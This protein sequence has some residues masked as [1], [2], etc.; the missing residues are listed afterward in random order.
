MLSTFARLQMAILKSLSFSMLQPMLLGRKA[1]PFDHPEFIFELKYDGFRALAIIL[2]GEC[3]LV[4]RNGNA[5]RSFE[6]LR[7]DFRQTSE[8]APPS[9]IAKSPVSIPH[10]GRC[11]MT[12][13]F[14]RRLG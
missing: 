12:C 14:Y 1:E 4:S 13:L 10:A 6:G 3:M 2:D 11:S 5:F 8:S 9:L 7:L